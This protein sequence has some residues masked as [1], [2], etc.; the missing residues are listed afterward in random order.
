MQL[1]R[2]RQICYAHVPKAH[3]RLANSA[4]CLITALWRADA[5]LKKSSICQRSL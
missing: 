1:V 3:R 4:K 5:A 2:K